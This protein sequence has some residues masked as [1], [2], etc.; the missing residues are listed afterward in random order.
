VYPIYRSGCGVVLVLVV[1]DVV[2]VDVVL[3]DVVLVDVVLVL[4]VVVVVVGQILQSVT[5]YTVPPAKVG[6]LPVAYPASAIVVNV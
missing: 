5:A 6:E 2:L 3:V 1:L 4:V